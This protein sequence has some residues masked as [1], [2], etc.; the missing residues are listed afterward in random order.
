MLQGAHT[1]GTEQMNSTMLCLKLTVVLS[2]LQKRTG[3]TSCYFLVM[4]ELETGFMWLRAT[5]GVWGVSFSRNQCTV[6]SVPS[7]PIVGIATRNSFIPLYSW[8]WEAIQEILEIRQPIVVFAFY[9]LRCKQAVGKVHSLDVLMSSLM[10]ALFQKPWL[11]ASHLT[12]CPWL[13]ILLA[14]AEENLYAFWFES[15]P[16][17]R[18][19][20][21]MGAKVC[22]SLR[23]R[24]LYN[25]THK[26]QEPALWCFDSYL[27]GN[28][29]KGQHWT[30]PITPKKLI[31][32]QGN[33]WV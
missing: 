1:L 3:S 15:L 17:S 21:R 2:C 24:P 23:V 25:N 22:P 13:Q 4:N 29:G 8:N 27:W 6:L 7:L 19:L 28:V 10:P 16:I 14:K 30:F 32:R 20:A 31:R 12:I 5:W 9:C 26:D 33:K 11:N 18:L